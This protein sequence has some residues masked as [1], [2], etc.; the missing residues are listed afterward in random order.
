ML[1]PFSDDTH[2]TQPLPIDQGGGAAWDRA[3]GWAGKAASIISIQTVTAATTNPRLLFTALTRSPQATQLSGRPSAT[4]EF[5][6][7]SDVCGTLT[8]GNSIPGA[9]VLKLH[10]H[11][12]L[13]SLLSFLWPGRS[14]ACGIIRY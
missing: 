11:A 10:V 6:S 3:C 7:G 13:S 14:E 12:P 8:E 4:A 1:T 5:S 9:T 2:V